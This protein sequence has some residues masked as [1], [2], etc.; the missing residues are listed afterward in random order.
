MD[1]H[2]LNSRNLLNSKNSG[3]PRTKISGIANRYTTA[4]PRQSAGN[5]EGPAKS[6]R[7]LGNT[8][9]IKNAAVTAAF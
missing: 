4:I 9:A 6:R 3:S 7:M 8:G 2:Q 5:I 1:P